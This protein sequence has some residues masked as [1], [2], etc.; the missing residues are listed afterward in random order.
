MRTRDRTIIT[1]KVY[2][3][4]KDQSQSSNHNKTVVVVLGV[5]FT[6]CLFVFVDCLF[7]WGVGVVVLFINKDRRPYNN[8]NTFVLFFKQGPE[9]VIA[10]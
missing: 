4:N 1:L 7:F 6:P 10:V 5:L 3:L 8:H 9:P 2:F